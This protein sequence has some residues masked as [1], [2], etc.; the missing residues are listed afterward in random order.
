MLKESLSEIKVDDVIQ[1]LSDNQE[2]VFPERLP[3][4]CPLA[5]YIKS[6]FLTIGAVNVGYEYITM[7]GRQP[8]KLTDELISFVKLCD[9]LGQFK[10][11]DVLNVYSII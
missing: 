5:M 9:S 8:I 4:H 3:T 11:Q 6:N 1:W 2:M 7:E 10:S